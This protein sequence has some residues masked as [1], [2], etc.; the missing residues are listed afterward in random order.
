MALFPQVEEDTHRYAYDGVGV[1][2][3]WLD[4][5]GL[6]APTTVDELYNVLKAFKTRDANGNGDPNDEIAFSSSNSLRGLDW[7]IAPWG[8]KFE[9]FYSDPHNPGKL[10]YWTEYKGGQA[11][12]DCM[13]TLARWYQEGLFE[14]DWLT[15]TEDQR[16]SKI[17]NDKT[18]M[19]H[20]WTANY[21][22][23]RDTIRQLKTGNVDNVRF[24]GM[25]PLVG[26]EGTAYSY[27]N[28][29]KGGASAASG[30][31][32]T[33]AAEK[34][35]K[36]DAALRLLDY[37]YSPAGTELIS[38]GVKG[39]TFTED[40]SGQ[41]HWGDQVTKSSTPLYDKLFEHCLAGYGD[42]PRVMNVEVFKMV[43]INDPDTVVAFDNYGK[44]SW[45]LL[46]PTFQLTANE[47]A[48]Y[49]AIM[50]DVQTAVREVYV[51]VLSGKRNPSEIPA[52][53][54]QVKSMGID[55]ATQI[56]Q[57][58]YDRYLQKK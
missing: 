7:L 20:M 19:V 40:A 16:N 18:G 5:L 28:N 11:F 57:G 46:V 49:N 4:R 24:Y 22:V 56:Y 45:D 50:N 38:F 10:T 36:M 6:K 15:Q 12:T 21:E 23:W 39:V 14:P 52:L 58:A 29:F 25:A 35:G 42:W 34:A 30:T 13:T 31:V 26:V 9:M 53:L 44:G 1:R 2:Q 55:R 37:M 17:L 47:S 32:I 41:K 33:K 27:I 43:E 48:E 3:D 8:L 54:R 51:G